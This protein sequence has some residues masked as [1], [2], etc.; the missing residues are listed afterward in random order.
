MVF[1]TSGWLEKLVGLGV[2]G[3]LATGCINGPEMQYPQTQVASR[4]LAA[5]PTEALSWTY[6]FYDKRTLDQKR[7]LEIKRT[8]DDSITYRVRR[9]GGRSFTAASIEELPHAQAFRGWAVDTLTE[10]VHENVTYSNTKHESVGDWKFPQSLSSW[11]APLD[12]DFVLITLFLDG[13]NTAGRAV[14]V[15]VGGGYTAARRAIGCVVHLQSSR[16]VWCNLDD[17]V[18]ELDQRFGAQ[19]E[20]DRLLSDMLSRGATATIEPPPARSAAARLVP[21][22]DV[23]PPPR[24]PPGP[25]GPDTPAPVHFH[26]AAKPNNGTP[27]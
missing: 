13:H 2:L 5:L 14:A 6:D 17:M 4:R 18:K 20:V 27:P 9:S 1:D 22:P 3:W 19:E 16:V 10:I 21:A 12:A 24:P 8:I 26:G 25:P 7:S 11:R 15:A 23:P